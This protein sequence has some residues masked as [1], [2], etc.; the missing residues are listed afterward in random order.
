ML[1]AGY[2]AKRF[3]KRFLMRIAAVAGVLFYVGMLTVPYA[4][5]A[6]GVAAAERH[7]YR[8]PGGDRHALFP[9]SDAGP[10]GLQ[11]P[12]SIPIPPAWAGSLQAHMA[13]VVAEIWNYHAVFWIALVMCTL[14]TLACLCE[15]QS[16]F[17]RRG[18]AL[19][20]QAQSQVIACVTASC[21]TSPTPGL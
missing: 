6:A 3:G 7:L 1:I 4:G 5:A 16:T 19:P 2:Y 9:G 11:P 15:N 12:P 17:H 13:G 14:T 18:R 8:D 10:G 20:A 21:R